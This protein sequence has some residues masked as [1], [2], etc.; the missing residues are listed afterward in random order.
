MPNPGGLVAIAIHQA[1]LRQLHISAS[2]TCPRS[3]QTSSSAWRRLSSVCASF[4]L[5]ATISFA[6]I[7]FISLLIELSMWSIRRLSSIWR[8][9]ASNSVMLYFKRN[10]SSWSFR[11][12]LNMI[13]VLSSNFSCSSSFSL[14]SAPCNRSN[15]LSVQRRGDGCVPHATGRCTASS[16]CFKRLDRFRRACPQLLAV[17]PLQEQPSLPFALQGSLAILREQLV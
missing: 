11:C 12:W 16:R 6:I 5:R 14:P 13:F 17:F 9:L 8:Y 3:W 1:W 4:F 7:S 10:K 15:H 2:C